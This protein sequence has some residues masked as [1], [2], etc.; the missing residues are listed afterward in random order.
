ML[1]GQSQYQ[2]SSMLQVNPGNRTAIGGAASGGAAGGRAAGGGAA[3]GGA[4]SGKP[5]G[6]KYAA[7][8]TPATS[9]T[10][11][12]PVEPV[13]PPSYDDAVKFSQYDDPPPAPAIPE[14]VKYEAPIKY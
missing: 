2:C 8:V 12:A 1:D 14:P 6:E 11:V 4:A 9:A 7:P 10:P 13:A 5:T 3:V